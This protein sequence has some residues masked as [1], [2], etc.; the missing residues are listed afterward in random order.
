MGKMAKN[1]MISIYRL[2]KDNPRVLVGVVEEPEKEGKQA[3]TCLKELW[4]ILIPEEDWK[5]MKNRENLGFL[6]KSERANLL[7]VIRGITVCPDGA[8]SD[9]NLKCGFKKGR[10]ANN[11]L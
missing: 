7:N 10:C 5:F 1:Y 6:D 9:I 4:G 2:E 8:N 11:F 3:F